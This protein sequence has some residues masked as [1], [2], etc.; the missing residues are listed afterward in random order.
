MKVILILLAIAVTI[1]A[2][3]NCMNLF[4]G[5]STYRISID[6]SRKTVYFENTDSDFGYF[7]VTQPTWDFTRMYPKVQLI[8]GVLAQLNPPPAS[9]GFSS[10]YISNINYLTTSSNNISIY[11]SNSNSNGI[12]YYHITFFGNI[13]AGFGYNTGTNSIMICPYN[14]QTDP[15]G[16]CNSYECYPCHCTCSL[17][18]GPGPGTCFQCNPGFY[19]QPLSHECHS[20]C[21]LGYYPNTTTNYCGTCDPSCSNCFASGNSSCTA[22]ATGYF[23]QPNSTT[24]LSSCPSS[25]YYKNLLTNICTT[26]AAGCK[27]CTSSTLSSCTSCNEGYYLQPS[28][29]SCLTTCPTGYFGNQTTN[30]CSAC[31]STCL[32]CSGPTSGEC[33][34]CGT[35]TFLNPYTNSCNATCPEGTYKTVSPNRCNICDPGCVLCTGAGNSNCVGCRPGYFKQPGLFDHV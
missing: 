23:L 21:P 34:S 4:R 5:S 27:A 19:L 20:T 13:C 31:N 33:T 14:A 30:A 1:T 22:C 8:Q 3:P 6:V 26:C 24:C 35:G 29:T 25:G 18:Y 11:G 12:Y 16:T 2:A 10:S 7:N 9:L 15:S 32:T 28:G 17:C